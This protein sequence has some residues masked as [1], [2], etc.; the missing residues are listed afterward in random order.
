MSSGILRWEDPAPRTTSI[1]NY[2]PIAAELR[3]NPGKWAVLAEMPDTADG[4]R[5]VSRLYN[6]V[7]YGYSGF[8]RVDDGT[9]RATTRTVAKDDGTKVVVVHAQYV[10]SRR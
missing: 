2:E 8:C 6:R 9:Y 4:R 1:D 7:K 10:N 5:E 3:N